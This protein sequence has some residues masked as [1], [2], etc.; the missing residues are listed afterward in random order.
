MNDPLRV[1]G[2]DRLGC[3]AHVV[4]GLFDRQRAVLLQG[5]REV[6]AAQQLHH[7]E[8]RAVVERANVVH[9]HDVIG[10]ERRRRAPLAQ[11]TLARFVTPRVVL[12]DSQH[13]DGDTLTEL[14]VRR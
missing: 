3:L 7:H 13:L 10:D 1:R 12:R 4:R 2:S 8:R 5:D 11:E 9:A 14:D 6:F